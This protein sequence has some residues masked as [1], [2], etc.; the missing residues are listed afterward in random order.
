MISIDYCLLF[1]LKH[2]TLSEDIEEVDDVDLKETDE[3]VS[4]PTSVSAPTCRRT[5][6][7][8][9]ISFVEEN[10]VTI[11][12]VDSDEDSNQ[13]NLKIPE[14]SIPTYISD[15]VQM[16]ELLT[17]Q[18]LSQWDYPIF[19]LAAVAEDTILSRVRFDFIYYLSLD[20]QF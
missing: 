6:V 8:L 5:S 12:P 16:G 20:N 15:D 9:H 4:S 19:D 3:P 2:H 1:L 13:V 10:T 11:Y 17:A 7:P 14:E 18:V